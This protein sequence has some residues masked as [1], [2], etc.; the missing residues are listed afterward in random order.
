MKICKKYFILIFSSLIIK[1]KIWKKD[2]DDLFDFEAEDIKKN[3][4]KINSFYPETYLISNNE[5]IFILNSNQDLQLKSNKNYDSSFLI[6]SEINYSNNSFIINNPIHSFN[7]KEIIKK[8]N[9]IT[10]TWKISQRNKE[11]EIKEGDIIKLGR[12]RLKFDKICIKNNLIEQNKINI[13]KQNTNNVH[14][15]SYYNLNLSNNNITNVNQSLNES[16]IS[17]DK[18]IHE[19]INEE[20]SSNHKYYCRICYRSDSD[21]ENPLI[22]PCKCSGSMQY[23]HYKCLKHFI[24]IK[25]QKKADENFKF[26]TWKNFECEICKYE[27][28]KYLKYKN[29]IYPMVDIENDYDSYAIC[30][31]TLFDDNKKKTFRRG[32]IIFKMNE[33]NDEITVGRTQSN[34]IKLKDISVSRNHCSIIKKNNKLYVLDKGSKFGTLI[35][36]NNPINLY[37]NKIN[38]NLEN[39]ISGRFS[40][41][42]GLVQNFSLFEK[43]FFLN[44]Q[45]CQCKNT[46][47][48]EVDV[49]NLK[50]SVSAPLVNNERENNCFDDSYEDYIL[51]LGTIIRAKDDEDINN[52]NNSDNSDKRSK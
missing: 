33:E 4:I 6:L 36:M 29:T 48:K 27:Y 39:L 42:I 30:D 21:I 38:D 40:F 25:M 34:K 18:N 37:L 7:L 13:L 51:D 50:E 16:K 22:S 20:S 32:L 19:N 15:N 31:Y 49:E 26:Y 47:D 17:N 23:I 2:T 5:E 11:S 10:R 12:V 41:S 43:L 24:D 46:N 45:C 28:P 44:L 8:K 3:E 14:N 52:V 35:Y 9:Q 1:T